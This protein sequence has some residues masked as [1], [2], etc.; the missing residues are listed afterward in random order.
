MKTRK[1]ALCYLEFN[2]AKHPKIAEKNK[3]KKK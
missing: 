1:L 3:K 2:I